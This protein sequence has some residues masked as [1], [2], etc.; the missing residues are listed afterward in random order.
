M[1]LVQ[2]FQYYVVMSDIVPFLVA[3]AAVKVINELQERFPSSHIM[4][5]LY[6]VYLQF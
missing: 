5:S 6:I 3:G 2:N 4:N 1:L